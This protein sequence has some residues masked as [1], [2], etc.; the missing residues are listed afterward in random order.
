[1]RGRRSA[2]KISSTCLP[3]SSDEQRG[4][5]LSAVGRRQAGLRI[6]LGMP[7]RLPAPSRQEKSMIRADRE[8]GRD[9]TVLTC[10]FCRGKGKDPFGLLSPLAQCQVCAG[11]GRVVIAALEQFIRPCAFCKGRGI[12]PLSRMACSCCLG[13]GVV[14]VEIDSIA[15]PACRGKGVS[16]ALHR[17]YPCSRCGGKGAVP[18]R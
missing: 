1:M 9:E 7:C 16:K 6:G 4:L 13:K 3:R 5:R 18:R 14:I 15:C 2:S 11:R 12:H 17:P 10:A 8:A